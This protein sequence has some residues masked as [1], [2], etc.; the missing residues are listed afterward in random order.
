MRSLLNSVSRVTSVLATLALWLSGIGLVA[1]TGIV[2]WQVYGRYV[3]NATPVWSEP[4]TL[5]LMGW[6]ILF[7][8]AVGV[9]ENF[10]LGLDLLHHVL[11]KAIG[12]IMDIVSLMLMVGF[13]AA[14]SWYSTQ[15][16]IG[17][18]SATLPALGIPGGW[19][20]MPLAIGGFLIALFALERLAER[21][22]GVEHAEV[23]PPV[24]EA[25]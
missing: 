23:V 15:L 20:Y 1:M 16:V 10:H 22:V 11:P 24:T 25:V 19:D 5:Q 9:R 7:G 12:R 6:F 13:G 17:T 21:L 14:M 8:A 2:G 3:L 18:W 4:I